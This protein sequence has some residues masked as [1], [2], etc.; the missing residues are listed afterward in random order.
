[1]PAPTLI[2][3]APCWIDLY[4]SDADRAA[5]FY[6][7]LLGWDATDPGPEYGGY[8]IWRRDPGP[9]CTDPASRARLR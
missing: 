4:S 9:S 8:R 1:M 7:A 2:A 5:A 6:G 3:G